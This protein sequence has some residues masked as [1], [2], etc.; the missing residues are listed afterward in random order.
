MQTR[1]RRAKEAT[2]ASAVRSRIS[3]R[4]SD[5]IVAM[6]HGGAGDW[7]VGG[8]AGEIAS[9]EKEAMSSGI[10]DFGGP[11]REWWA[12]FGTVTAALEGL[13]LVGFDLEDED[14]KCLFL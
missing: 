10:V 1:E 4:S 6:R 5:G 3:T 11:S 12:G 2:S 13:G 8:G 9:V 14:G 7:S